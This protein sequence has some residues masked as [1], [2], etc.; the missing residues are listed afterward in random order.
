M[1]AWFQSLGGWGTLFVAT[2]VP[3]TLILL[4]QTV[5]LLF[6]LGGEDSDMDFD[7]P[8]ADVDF[9]STETDAG[10]PGLQIFTVRGFVAFFS[11]FG[12][13]GLVM[14]KA[15]L[16]GPLSLLLAVVCGGVAMVLHGLAFRAAMR[17][18][19]NGVISLKNA[20][21]QSGTVYLTVPA[22][23]NG[24]GKVSVLV[25]SRYGEYDAVT[26]E[27]TPI[28]TG[29]EIVVVGVSGGTTLLVHRK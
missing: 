22:A 19:S 12:W 23:R 13:S 10:D 2:A 26:D 29:S 16:P 25:Q 9:D 20:V 4:I 18:Q 8:D 14:Y 24:Q 21:G 17:L 7:G 11:I 27:E 28:P 5:L 6:G 3:A 1:L 15:G